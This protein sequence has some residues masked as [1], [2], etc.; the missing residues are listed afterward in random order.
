MKPRSAPNNG[1]HNKNKLARAFQR[2]INL[3]TASKIASTNGVGIGTYSHGDDGDDVKRK[4]GLKALIAMVFASVTSIK[5]AYAE[6]Q[7]AQHPYDGEAIQVADQAVVEQLKVLSEL[8]HKFLKQDLDLSPQVT[9]MLAEIQE[10]QSMMRTYDITIKNLESDIEEKDSAIDLHHKQLEHCIAFNKSTEK[11]LNETGPLFMFDNIQFTTLNP[12]H[13]IQVLHCAL[14]SVRSYV[15]LMMKEMELAKWDIVAATKAIEPSAMLAKQSHACFL[16]ESFVCKTMLQGFDSHDFSGLKSLHREQ[17]FN[18]FK[19]LKSANPKSFLVQNPKSGFAK[20]IRDKYLKLVHPK[21]EC[22]FFGNL[23]QRKMVIS[24]GFSDTAFFMAFTEMGR[25]FWLLHCLGLSMSDQV[26][27]FQV[28]KGYRFSEVYMEN[29][30]EE[31]LFIDE[32]VDGADVDF[33]VGFTVVPGF[34]IGKTVIQS[35][36]YLS[37][38]I[39]PNGTSLLD[40]NTLR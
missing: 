5:A 2:V 1:T 14:K 17:Y 8:R 39:N 13:F 6:L 9:L 29:V 34:K 4:A 31:S 21:M 12:S 28:M 40:G 11:K 19:T 20:F 22:S 30:S 24:G 3:R 36:V 37:P 18:E 26:S 16:F 32:I 25:R 15:R 38:V 23:N 35:Q 27:V 7:M 10:Q 33:R